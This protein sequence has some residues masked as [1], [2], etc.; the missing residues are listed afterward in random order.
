MYECEAWHLFQFLQTSSFLSKDHHTTM[1]ASVSATAG[2]SRG[3]DTWHPSRYL[4]PNHPDNEE[5]LEQAA[6]QAAVTRLG[7]DNRQG[8]RKYKPRRTVDFM[9]PVLKW[10]QVGSGVYLDAVLTGVDEQAEGCGV[11]AAYTS[12][13]V[14]LDSCGLPIL[15]SP[16]FELTH[17]S[18]YHR[19]PIVTTLQ[20]PCAT[21]SST[22]PS[23]KNGHRP[24]SSK[25]VP[26]VIPADVSGLLMPVVYSPGT[27]KV[28]SPC[29]TV[30]HSTT[31]PLLKSTT[32]PS[33]LSPT[34]I[35]VR[36]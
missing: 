3:P 29:G 22:P 7:G 35:M 12:E 21:I 10:R 13:S 1:A 17:R 18:Y 19:T 25:F 8:A 36:L 16:V 14:R 32:I 11:Y 24:E 30:L 26:L 5:V 15:H 27:I 33:A 23:I 20:H 4:E 2:P 31:N 34:P 28:N 6:Y 9:G